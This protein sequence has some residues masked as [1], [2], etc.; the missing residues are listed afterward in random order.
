MKGLLYR[1]FLLTRPVFMIV[2][3]LDI[4]Y[5]G[6]I[7]TIYL[8][9]SSS[10]LSVFPF[11]L[12]LFLFPELFNVEILRRDESRLWRGFAASAPAAQKGLVA[13]KYLFLLLFGLAPLFLCFIVST[14]LPLISGDLSA[15]ILMSCFLLFCLYLLMNAIEV[16]FMIRFGAEK[17]L[18][19]KCALAG[20]LLCIAAVYL[21]FG[22]ISF[23]LGDDPIE[24]FLKL[25]N[26]SAGLWV[27]AALP[28]VSFAAYLLSFWISVKLY[29][30]GAENDES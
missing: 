14:L 8:P 10:G 4:I 21:L 13:E 1:D 2:T 30:K 3:L 22:D 29:R 5:C 11:C 16:P 28:V 7:V 23:L 18:A 12:F 20:V 24:G 15:S 25:M 26:S 19:I 27:T 6:G 17:G 9:N